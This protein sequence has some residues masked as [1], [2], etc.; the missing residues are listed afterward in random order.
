[1]DRQ[2]NT[3][4]T[5]AG[6]TNAPISTANLERLDDLHG[7]KVADGDPDIR[8]WS[9]RTSDGRK[10]G[11]VDSLIVDTDAN[12]VR[13]IDIELDGKALSLKDNR[14]VLV[15]LSGARLDDH[16]DDVLLTGI[17]GAQLIAM[18]PYRHGE[19]VGMDAGDRDH[20][21]DTR[22]F[23]GK[24][25]GTG[26]VERLTLAEE[27]LRVGKRAVSA[28]EA[29]VHKTVESTH[30]S[31]TVPLAHEEL[32]IEKRPIQAGG[33]TDGSIGE[34]EVVI[35]LMQEEAVVDKRTV[36]REEVVI[37][38]KLVTDEKTVEADLKRE[39]L[40]VDRTDRNTRH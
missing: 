25:E 14:H 39:K 27:E 11:E 4:G 29:R 20:D 23:Y 31:E 9:V 26:R 40:D 35:P 2:T 1:M 38:K 33:K 19:P 36:A 17:D 12:L 18:P 34:D 16:R 13:Y 30:V 6:R 32:V 7:Y 37:R 5:T 22:E 24:R 3:T 10:V 15:P 21:R 28:G 8:G